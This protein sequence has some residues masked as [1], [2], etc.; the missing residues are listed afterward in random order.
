[1]PVESPSRKAGIAPR[2]NRPSP[3]RAARAPARLRSGSTGDVSV[4]A[5]SAV[6]ILWHSPVRKI[7]PDLLR[8]LDRRD[9]EVVVRNSPERA[10]AEIVAR[11]QGQRDVVPL[12]LLLYEPTSLANVTGMAAVLTR[13]APQALCWAYSREADPS[14]YAMKAEELRPVRPPIRELTPWLF[15]SLR[16]A[17]GPSTTPITS[18]SGGIASDTGR[19]IPDDF[20]H[21]E[22]PP[23]LGRARQTRPFPLSPTSSC[24]QPTTPP[25]GPSTPTPQNQPPTF[26]QRVAVSDEE[27][28]MLLGHDGEKM[29][30][31]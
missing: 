29:R 7:N 9:L 28:A 19:R 1:M 14:L 27:I 10:F 26:S 31:G 15:P 23:S 21:S 8:A 5:R 24:S 6:C 22:A 4:L 18:P 12:I 20:D 25:A 11:R 17:E 16:D 13:Y 3:L 30:M 2:S